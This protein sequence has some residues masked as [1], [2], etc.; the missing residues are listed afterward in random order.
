VSAAASIATPPAGG[1]PKGSR[2]LDGPGRLAPWVLASLLVH[3]VVGLALHDRTLS[4]SEVVPVPVVEPVAWVEIARPPA[5]EPRVAPP[6]PERAPAPPPPSSPPPPQ[7]KPEPPRER[8][9]RPSPEPPPP[10]PEPAPPEPVAEPARVAAAA[11]VD[12]AAEP[13]EDAAPPDT[14]KAARGAAA[15]AAATFVDTVRRRVDGLKRYPVMAR[16]RGVEDKVVARIRID[17]QGRLAGYEPVGRPDAM[18]GRSA[19]QAIEAAAPFPPPPAGAL[20]VEIA[21]R[22]SLDAR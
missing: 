11:P 19:R 13:A 5:P 6:P 15:D 8:A 4:R 22:F 2:R 10:P 14:A 12:A 3:A 16:R 1:P 21:L 9:L 17:E 18:L 20:R 7:P